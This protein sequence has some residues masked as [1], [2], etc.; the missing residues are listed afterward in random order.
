MGP[1]PE[2]WCVLCWR[3]F[4]PLHGVWRMGPGGSR[5]R[6][7]QAAHPGGWGV[8]REALQLPLGLGTLL[9]VSLSVAEAQCP[10][11]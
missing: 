5:R 7:Q 3:S 10:H 1:F 4:P 6:W 11:L 9:P 2:L 8:V